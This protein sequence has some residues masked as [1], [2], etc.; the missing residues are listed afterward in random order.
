MSTYI[1]T[2]AGVI[3]P[4]EILEAEIRKFISSNS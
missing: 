4:V 1:V 2:P 3:I